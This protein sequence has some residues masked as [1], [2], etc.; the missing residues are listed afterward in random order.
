QLISLVIRDI[1]LKLQDRLGLIFSWSTS[2]AVSIIIG[3]LFLNLPTTAAGAFTRGGVLFIGLLFNVFISFVELPS[4]MLGRP[5]MW[6]QSGFCFYRPGALALANSISD[7]PFSAPKIVLFS[8]ILYMMAGLTRT[9][10]AFFTYIVIVYFTFLAL[11]SF[12]R[13]LGAISFSFDTAARLASA[14][15]ITMS[16]YS[17]YMIQEEA[18]KKW[19]IWLYYLNPVNYAFSALMANEFKHMQ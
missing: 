3:S 13:F 2:I 9:A 11:S 8:F 14:L 18:M 15:V 12:F 16:M 10:G 19:L 7:V 5:I 6:R 17:G 1:Q 4:Q